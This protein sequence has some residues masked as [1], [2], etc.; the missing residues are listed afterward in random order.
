MSTRKKPRNVVYRLFRKIWRSFYA[1]I[2]ALVNSVLRSLM[3]HKR[4][5]SRQSQAG[6]VLPTVV[7]V[8]LV[9]ALLTTA[10]VIRSF[11]RAKN[12]SNIRVDQAVLNAATPALDRAR[13]KLEQLFSPQENALSGN[14]P[15]EG[16]SYSDVGTISYALS[17]PRYTFG[18]ETQLK[19]VVETNG[20]SGFQKQD[21]MKTAWKFPVDT[22]NDGKFDT[23]TLYGIY[24]R[25]PTTNRTRT[26]LEARALPQATGEVGLCANPG[27]AA[28]SFQQQQGWFEVDGQLK[29]A[30]F[31]YVANVPITQADIDL[32]PQD[33]KDKYKEYRGNQSFSGL[34]MQQDQ[35]RIALDNNAV[36][37]RDDLVISNVPP[38]NLNGRIHTNSNLM[39]ANNG[40]DV[41]TLWQVSS[42][43]S[44][45]YTAENAKIIVGGHVAAGDITGDTT[46]S[47][48]DSS[49]NLVEIHLYQGTTTDPS[50]SDVQYVNNQNKTTTLNP[51][52][53]ATNSSA[54]DARLNLLVKA[55][56]KKFAQA[57]PNGPVSDTNVA[58]MTGTYPPEVIDSFKGKYSPTDPGSGRSILT[59]ILKTYFAERIRF[60]S[61]NEVPIT[62][63]PLNK[64]PTDAQPLTEDTV[65][66]AS[67]VIAPP[68][69]WMRFDTSD[70]AR[71]PVNGTGTQIE[72]EA[73]DPDDLGTGSAQLEYNIGDR[74]QV[75]NSLPRRWLKADNTTY[76]QPTDKQDISGVS[77][78]NTNGTAKAGTTRYRKGLVQQLD[79]L[80]DTS[81]GGYWERAAALSGKEFEDPS[82]KEL[83]GGLRVV[84]GAGIYID[85]NPRGTT[86]TGQR[87]TESFLPTPPAKNAWELKQ[88]AAN[89][90]RGIKLPPDILSQTNQTVLEKVPVVW[91]DTMPMFDWKDNNNNGIYD[92]G[93]TR[94]GDLQMRATVVYH[95]ADDPSAGTQQAPIACIA[96]LYDPTNFLT[97]QNVS[98]LPQNPNQATTTFGTSLN[99]INYPASYASVSART[100]A[101]SNQRLL[102]Q[103]NMLFPDGRWVN[104]PLRKALIKLNADGI[105]GL[106]VADLAAID[107]A[108]CALGI[109]DAPT[110]FLSSGDVPNFAIQEQ[111]FLDARQVKALR[112]RDTQAKVQPNGTV[113]VATLQEITAAG[114]FTDVTRATTRQYISDPDKLKIAELGDLSLPT[115]SADYSLPLEQRQPLEIRATQIDLEALRTTPVTTGAGTGINNK[116]EYLLPNSGIIY[117]SRDD[118][119]LDITDF[120]PTTGGDKG[121][122][123]TDFKL[124]PT[125]RPNGILLVNGQNLAR[126]NDYRIAEKGLI[127]ATDLP[128]YI[129]GSFNRH[130]KP[131]TTTVREEFTE[132]LDD[133]YDNFYDRE[134]LN[135][136]FACRP[137]PDNPTACPDDGDQWRAARILSDA[138]TL[139]SSNFRFGYRY[140]GD[141]D[142]NNNIGNLAVESRLKNG[143][144]WNSFATSADWYDTATG[145]P[146]VDFVP[147]TF[148]TPSTGN[149]TGSTY[150]TNGVTPIQRR[151]TFTEYKMEICRKLPV[152]A[153]GPGDW[154]LEIPDGTP[155]KGSGTTA[156]ISDTPTD[157]RYVPPADR[158]YPRRVAFKR[159]SLG[160]LEMP[161]CIANT[162]DVNCKAIPIAVNATGTTVEVPYDGMTG[163]VAPPASVANALWYLTTTAPANPSA[164]TVA[165]PEVA[166]FASPPSVSY[167]NTNKLYY[168][169]FEPEAIS[170]R[171]LI[172]P[173]VPE[174]P[175]V[176]N[177][178]SLNSIPPTSTIPSPN[179]ISAP[180]DYSV[181]GVTTTGSTPGCA[182]S[183]D[184]KPVVGAPAA[185]PADAATTM[186]TIGDTWAKLLNYSQATN[187]SVVSI[188]DTTF[189]DLYAGSA[190][191]QNLE[192]KAQAKVNIYNLPTNGILSGVNITLDRNNRI[193][194]PIFVFRSRAG[195][196]N[197]Q[198]INRVA[199]TL[200]G[201]DPNNIFWVVLENV[202]IR[203]DP[204]ANQH[205]LAG[206]FINGANSAIAF[207]DINAT[208]AFSGT[209]SEPVIKGGRILGFSTPNTGIPNGVMTAMT[210][211]A[212]PLLIP[213]LNIHSPQ[214][215]PAD[216]AAAAFGGNSINERYWV[217]HVPSGVTET[218]NAVLIMGDSPLRPL[219][220][221]T[222]IDSGEGGGGLANF[223]RFLEAWQNPGGPD[224]DATKSSTK[225]RGSFIQFKRSVF[226][227]AP[228]EAIDNPQQDNS[229]FFDTPTGGTTPAYMANFTDAASRPYIYKGGAQF[230]KAPYYRAPNRYWGYDVG[231]L[232]QTPDLFARR[233]STPSAGTP[234]EYYREVGRGDRWIQNLL[235]A[236]EQTAG[237]TYGKWAIADPKQRP[238]DCQEQTPSP[239]KYND[240]T[241]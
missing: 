130:F 93:E 215:S 151:A 129:K 104:E 217:Q 11:D 140:E 197:L 237:T 89:D 161:N 231:L 57:Y 146:K 128:V 163:S 201:V 212:E 27:N 3:V 70:P 82:T 12:A 154:T 220:G 124:D 22:D 100:S 138:V 196:P 15:P 85:G 214:G 176:M 173:G 165:T 58:A 103:A 84:T 97:A 186:A 175:R 6:F 52:Q 179:P 168:A 108:N 30:F 133:E 69:E 171:Q 145:Y 229:L 182:T 119:L 174:F 112:K 117:A 98:S 164:S 188:D 199:L 33:E 36:W 155:G 74:I 121:A 113:T 35:G 216:N 66:A 50:N 91:P 206:N 200:K 14:P 49:E 148:G 219:P 48:T 21:Q 17:L 224:S 96:T 76:A 131:G 77:W 61:F 134:T 233:F 144:W 46:G 235:C 225:I 62:A 203:V 78:L 42:L 190:N 41:I 94:R 185:C 24:F 18:D 114:T 156:P 240:P 31:T 55:A 222:G 26:P 25:N 126:T 193:D 111:A 107:A 90:P 150:V 28:S 71:L 29:K 37:Y 2:T 135:E 65:F 72:L 195:S 45:F 53:I 142:L 153:C 208:A 120:D 166:A 132:L 213:V 136:S 32:L 87:G 8:L 238:S 226:A 204:G 109:L 160:E 147:N 43:S 86:G 184:Y 162:A 159:N 116:N 81:R 34:E 99:G 79:D 194:D 205:Q 56:L 106:S 187:D 191:S 125:R 51:A 44:C 102:T 223:P 122:S 68:L 115:T 47:S 207:L 1:V 210:T 10:I 227:T 59:Q 16:S 149:Q 92:P 23:F 218:Y 189:R 198:F 181:F 209:L 177:I 137:N 7:M 230:R 75:G 20:Q 9:V 5:R 54:Y 38:F 139:L 143:F 152:A 211:T 63:N 80:G 192:L 202:G 228:F 110:S 232:S 180:S 19:V 105:N 158:R 170:E 234:N 169:P 172:L 241:T 221:L 60:V 157:P 127:L 13:A 88:M 64:T 67:G 83:A 123:A 40:G 39:V 178:A 4:R 183:Q 73:T 95:Y 167:N 236:A 101:T 118:A 141:F 239:A